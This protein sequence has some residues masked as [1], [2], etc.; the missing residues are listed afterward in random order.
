MKTLAVRLGNLALK[1]YK[2]VSQ[3]EDLHLKIGPTLEIHANG[4]Q[5]RPQHYDHGR[6][7]YA[8]KINDCKT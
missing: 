3:G 2:L 6:G 7:A 4:P 1:H 5:K 8:G